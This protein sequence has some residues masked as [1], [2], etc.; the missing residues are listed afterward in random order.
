MHENSTEARKPEVQ[1]EPVWLRDDE[2]EGHLDRPTGGKI[3]VQIHAERKQER[4]EDEQN[5]TDA[6]NQTRTVSLGT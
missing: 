5:R 2:V 3:A 1:C 6:R 4:P